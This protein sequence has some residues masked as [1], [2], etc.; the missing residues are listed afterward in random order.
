MNEQDIQDVIWG[1]LGTILFI[2]MFIFLVL[3]PLL[4]VFL[5]IYVVTTNALVAAMLGLVAEAIF[6]WFIGDQ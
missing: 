2:A 6:I 1:T 3:S 4:V 5:F